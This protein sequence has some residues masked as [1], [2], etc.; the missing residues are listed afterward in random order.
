[1]PSWPQYLGP[2]ST[3]QPVPECQPVPA[4]VPSAVYTSSTEFFFLCTALRPPQP[5]VVPQSGGQSPPLRAHRQFHF[6][7]SLNVRGPKRVPQNGKW[8]CCLTPSGTVVPKDTF[9]SRP[10]MLPRP[11]DYQS[12]YLCVSLIWLCF[13]FHKHRPR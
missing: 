7:V 5:A 10:V 11:L 3:L 8:R 12:R 13:E 2:R 1:M 9:F 6:H 4:I